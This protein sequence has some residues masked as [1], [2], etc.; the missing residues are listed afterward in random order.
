[1]KK[2]HF[3]LRVNAKLRADFY[4]FCKNKGF[5]AGGAVKLFIKQLINSGEIPF[6]LREESR[7]DGERLDRM[8][9][10]M[11]EETRIAFIQ[12]CGEIGVNR[13]DIIRRFMEYC[14]AHDAFPTFSRQ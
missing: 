9:V 12:T 1:M 13:S 6:S 7:Y 2:G 8:S 14:V 11:D 10:N 5:S 3:P 4:A